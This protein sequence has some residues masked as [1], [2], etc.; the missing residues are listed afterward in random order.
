MN[1]L[2]KPIKGKNQK[3]E[4]MNELRFQA[5]MGEYLIDCSEYYEK[6]S[7]RKAYAMNDESALRRILESEY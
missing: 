7:I 2:E 4:P 3:I 1:E 5:I 6:Q